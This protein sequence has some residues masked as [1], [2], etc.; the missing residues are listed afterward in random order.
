MGAT[1][2]TDKKDYEPTSARAK[3]VASVQSRETYEKYEEGDQFWLLENPSVAKNAFNSILDAEI[4]AFEKKYPTKPAA[5]AVETA[6]DTEEIKAK[7]AQYASYVAE[8]PRLNFAKYDAALTAKNAAV[9]TLNNT[10]RE[11][12]AAEAA[13]TPEEKKKVEESK[14]ADDAK[15]KLVFGDEKT[16]VTSEEFRKNWAKAYGRDPIAE[17]KAKKAKEEK[18]KADKAAAD[19]AAATAAANKTAEQKSATTTTTTTTTSSAQTAPAAPA[20]GR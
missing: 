4:K 3:C 19:A 5:Q 7:R 9:V 8:Q 1:Q 2:S 11:V 20:A 10:R 14:A 13:K 6:A 17:D 18:A 16:G 12:A 15:F